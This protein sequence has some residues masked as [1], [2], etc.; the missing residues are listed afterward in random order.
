MRFQSLHTALSP[1]LKTGSTGFRRDRRS[2]GDSSADAT[3]GA[4]STT[5][6]S[7]SSTKSLTT[8]TGISA[9]TI[10]S[11]GTSSTGS[12]TTGSNSGAAAAATL[13]VSGAASKMSMSGTKS[14]PTSSTCAVARTYNWAISRFA[15]SG[16]EH[17]AMQRVLRPRVLIAHDCGYS[18]RAG[19]RAILPRT[20]SD[21]ASLNLHLILQ[22]RHVDLQPKARLERVRQ[23]EL[24]LRFAVNEERPRGLACPSRRPTPAVRR[25]RRDR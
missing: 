7:S 2:A 5:V 6:A 14:A 18:A 17:H 25:G 23:R 12:G 24:R 4:S 22:L 10:G 21:S 9:S 1:H 11:P 19:S 15:E 20:R 13:K 3:S 8:A 16:F